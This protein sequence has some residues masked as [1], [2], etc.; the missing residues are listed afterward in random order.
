MD[1]YSDSDSGDAPYMRLSDHETL[2]PPPNDTVVGVGFTDQHSS[3]S[4]SYFNDVHGRLEEGRRKTVANTPSLRTIYTYYQSGGFAALAKRRFAKL[5]MALFTIAFAFVLLGDFVHYDVLFGTPKP[6]NLHL[7]LG[8]PRQFRFAHLFFTG[9]FLLWFG[10]L[11]QLPG[12]LQRA[13]RVKRFCEQ[14]L[15][16]ASDNALRKLVWTD[17]VKLLHQTERY[18]WYENLTPL[19]FAQALMIEENALIALFDKDVLQLKGWQQHRL[20]HFLPC[21]TRSSIWALRA[22]IFNFIFDERRV[23]YSERYKN[24]HHNTHQIARVL[25][26]RLVLA[27]LVALA[28]APFLLCYRLFEFLFRYGE[29]LHKRRNVLLA[30]TWTTPAL[31]Q[32]RTYNELPHLFAKRLQSAHGPAQQY[33]QQFYNLQHLHLRR[34]LTYILG[35]LLFVLLSFI[36]WD[37]GVMQVH[38]IGRYNVLFCSAVLGTLYAFLAS[39]LPTRHISFAPEQHMRKL[40]AITEYHTE[41][42]Q[43]APDSVEARK[44]VEARFVARLFNF[45][46]EMWGVI[47]TPIVLWHVARH[48]DAL[49]VFLHTHMKSVPGLGPVL[50]EAEFSTQTENLESKLYQSLAIFQRHVPNWQPSHTDSHSPVSSILVES[51]EGKVGRDEHF[52]VVQLSTDPILDESTPL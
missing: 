43:H 16:I 25:R 44:Q 13:Y 34:V 45:W 48:T 50:T 3:P 28:L 19:K 20:W 8:W 18:R 9:L 32:F 52:T 35:A 4:T 5:F 42:W 24:M 26:W 21:L 11:L 2:I 10:Y 14:H 38:V 7:A 40:I 33:L 47:T 31:W 37:E 27:G 51:D 6:A 23:D 17:L 36:V 30:R 29:A 12:K 46:Y 22:A 1:V 39:S 49:V 41:T 15:H